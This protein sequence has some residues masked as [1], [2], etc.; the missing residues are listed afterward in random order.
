[1]PTPPRPRVV[2]ASR[3]PLRR[4]PQLLALAAVA[5]PLVAAVAAPAG[6]PT[7]RARAVAPSVPAHVTVVDGL[8]VRLGVTDAPDVGGALAEL[9]VATGPLDRVV[10]APDTPLDGPTTVVIERVVVAAE[11][12][13]VELAAPTVRIEDPDLLQGYVEVDEEG[14]AGLRIDTTLVLHV[15][16]SVASRLHLRS[17]PV[18][19][20]EPR[21]ERVG[22]GT[23]PADTVWDVLARC[24]ASGRWDAE[25]V[26]DGRVVHRGGLQFTDTTWDAFR[27]AEF[28][29][30]A[31]DATREQQIHVA[32]RVLARQ[33]W[34]AWPTCS[35][36]LGLR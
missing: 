36:R 24:E 29:E 5:L 10:P 8:G 21:I 33:G 6:A 7:E 12:R 18:S 1:M 2:G 23:R 20:P 13:R 35:A 31:S 16:G 22:T 30:L 28:P 34:G 26:V 17:T 4:L 25:G 15:D 32:E 19:E 9:D 14:R 27:P 11:R 3:R